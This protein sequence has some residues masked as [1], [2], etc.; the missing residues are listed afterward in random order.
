MERDRLEELHVDGKIILKRIFRKWDDSTVWMYVAQNG[1]RRRDLV[2][3]EM[4]PS[5]SIKYGELRFME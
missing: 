5:G 2:Y 4:N 3:A 1:D